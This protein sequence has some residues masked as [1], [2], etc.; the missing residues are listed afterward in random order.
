MRILLL[1]SLKILTIPSSNIPPLCICSAVSPVLCIFISDIVFY[2]L[3]AEYESFYLL[4]LCFTLLCACSVCMIA[5]SAL[6]LA[7]ICVIAGSAPT[8]DFYP[9]YESY[10]P[11]SLGAW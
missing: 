2:I 1:L 3:E 11:A 6:L 10:I 5:V 9:H 8:S 7:V 4:C